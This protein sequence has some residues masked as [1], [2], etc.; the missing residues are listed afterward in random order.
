MVGGKKLKSKAKKG[1]NLSSSEIYN[2]INYKNNK[3]IFMH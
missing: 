2:Q 3:P 1:G